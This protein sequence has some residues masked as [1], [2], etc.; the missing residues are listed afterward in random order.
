[1]P[2]APPVNLLKPPPAPPKRPSAPP[3]PA[4]PVKAPG[5]N[6]GKRCSFG[7]IATATAQRIAIFGTG[8]IGKTSIAALAP[9]PVAFIDLDSS[10]PVLKPMLDGKG[11]KIKVADG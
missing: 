5:S 8:G 1:M 6:N 7:E 2:E 9:G 3:P 4:Q 10:L 11:L